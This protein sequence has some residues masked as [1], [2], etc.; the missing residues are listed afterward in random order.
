MEYAANL[1]TTDV[2]ARDWAAQ[3]AG[4]GWDLLAV[5]DHL[6]SSGRGWPHPWVAAASMAAAAPGL[7]VTTAFAN[8]LFRHPVEFAQ[9][10]LSLH[11]ESGGRFEAGLGAGWAREELV[12]TGRPYP[13]PGERVE[14]YVEALQICR[15][16]F[17][18]GSCTHRGRWYEVDLDDF[19]EPAPIELVGSLGGPRMIR[20]AAPLLDRIELKA[21]AGATRGGSLE[22][23]ALAAVTEMDLRNQIDA[24]RA[25]NEHAPLGLFVLCGTLDDPRARG[26]ASAMRTDSLS[27]GFFARAEQIVASIERL[28]DV[29]IDRVTVAPVN[30]S[31]FTQIAAARG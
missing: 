29:G 11:R 17:G 7:R 18:S 26:I 4:E 19:C 12:R 20:E 24:V 14:R 13:S 22:I 15:A 27:A 10:A 3:R 1:M 16:L 25:V 28:A 5:A 6:Y 9:A 31:A 23:G 2:A 21:S 30:E 8:N